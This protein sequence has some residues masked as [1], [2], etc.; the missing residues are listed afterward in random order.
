M[1]RERERERGREK[2]SESE[3]CGGVQVSILCAVIK[4]FAWG[5]IPRDDLCFH[6]GK[7]FQE[8]AIGEFYVLLIHMVRALLTLNP[9]F[10]FCRLPYTG[11][12]ISLKSQRIYASFS[13]A[14][15]MY[16]WRPT[17]TLYLKNNISPS[18]KSHTKEQLQKEEFFMNKT[19]DIDTFNTILMHLKARY[20]EHQFIIDVIIRQVIRASGHNF[21]CHSCNVSF[22]PLPGRKIELRTSKECGVHLDCHSQVYPGPN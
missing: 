8:L 21:D 13:R 7:W 20:I 3:N 11:Q 18:T 4:T 10:I 6:F 2:A 22:L 14:C 16:L 19:V 15:V 9:R 17:N 12:N 5:K 1:W